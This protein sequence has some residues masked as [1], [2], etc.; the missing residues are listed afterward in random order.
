MASSSLLSVR[1]RAGCSFEAREK[2]DQVTQ[3]L[4]AQLGGDV[5]RHRGRSAL[6]LLDRIFRDG[7]RLAVGGHE[8]HFLGVFAAQDSGV[9]LAVARGDH[10]RFEP[11]RDLLVGVHESIRADRPGRASHRRRRAP[12]RLRRPSPP[13]AHL[14]TA[15]AL[16][17][18]PRGEEPATALSIA[19]RKHFTK[20]RKRIVVR[21]GRLVLLELFAKLGLGSLASRL[22]QVELN[23]RRSFAGDQAIEP[24]SQEGG[25]PRPRTWR[26]GSRRLPAARESSHS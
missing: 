22:D 10:H 7:D 14:V 25:E 23:L 4:L 8:P 24:V 18:G 13:A 3:L 1:R 5:V 19:P 21:F 9:H 2:L 12:G 6:A 16:D 11:L 17:L 20:G 26:P 15:N